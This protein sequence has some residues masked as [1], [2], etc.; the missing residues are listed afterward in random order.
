MGILNSYY[1]AI[2]EYKKTVGND[3][4]CVKQKET[5]RNQSAETEFIAVTRNLCVIEEDWI[6][7]I[8]KGLVFVQKAID[9][10]RQ[11]IKTNGEVVPIEKAKHVSKDS[12]E[13]LARHSDLLTR[14]PEGDDIIP[15]KIYNTERLTDFAVYEN[16]FL[17]LLLTYLRDFIAL[18][19]DKI[20]KLTNLYN[21]ELQIKKTVHSAKQHIEY[22]LFLKE[23][24]EDD[25]Y[26]RQNNPCKALIDRIDAIYKL[27]L[28]FLKTPLMEEVA[29]TPKLR[30]PV[31][32]T[33][34]LKM[35]RNFKAA[36]ALYEYVTAYE[37]QG[38]TVEQRVKKI[39]G[40]QGET[41]ENFAESVAA[42][43][44]LCYEHGL[45]I[46]GELSKCYAE[47]E[48]K[49][50]EEERL[51]LKEQIASIERKVKASG[52]GLQEY[53]LALEKRNKML[54][55]CEEDLAVMNREKESLLSV[56][57]SKDKEIV[58]LNNVIN[59]NK[60]A[61]AEEKQRTLAEFTE[62]ENAIRL[63]SERRESEL[64]AEHTER[65]N[66]I[67]VECNARL[68]A[69]EAAYAS[70]KE[71]LVNRIGA[72]NEEIE[73][74]LAANK[75]LICKIKDKE[76]EIAALNKEKLLTAAKY[77]G[78]RKQYGL[79]KDDE[80]FTT[81]EAF[82]EIEA[83][84][85]AFKTF[86]KEEWSKTKK[87]IRKENLK[88]RTGK[89]SEK[90]DKGAAE[91]RQDDTAAGAIAATAKAENGA[92]TAAKVESAETTTKNENAANSTDKSE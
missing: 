28:S 62:K 5:I 88:F 14:K 71:R 1:R 4:N 21:G 69:S 42:T 17:Y 91:I 50:K 32:K 58:N 57:G 74:A 34:V 51:K 30:P 37:K 6:I 13:H 23:K 79:I 35:N 87:R 61:Y 63:E 76:G 73:S 75:N 3:R 59:E 72:A 12:V 40:F 47:E 68:N 25:E 18:R 84:Y 67:V 78:I 60:V 8:E 77:N 41:A 22:A 83:Q 56:I 90:H 9:E 82:N 86:F 48:E 20:L 70:E 7:E 29:K 64:I 52:M 81:E 43:S 89:S 31:T 85:G 36:V 10:N 46:N 92:E 11:F 44:F 66:K 24:R 27:T 53:M 80:D 54:E 65:E 15:D 55:R 39:D 33:N 49:R 2:T 26:L 16:R 45:G 38:F 19:Y